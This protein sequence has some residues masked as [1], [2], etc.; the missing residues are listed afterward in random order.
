MS[1][2]VPQYQTR[3]SI[4]GGATPGVR[5]Q[6]PGIC[7]PGCTRLDTHSRPLHCSVE[8]LDLGPTEPWR[9]R[10]SD[11]ALRPAARGHEPFVPGRRYVPPYYRPRRR[12][13]RIASDADPTDIG[14]AFALRPL[15]SIAIKYLVRAGF[16]PGQSAAK[17]LT[18]ALEVIQREIEYLEVGGEERD[19]VS[20][21][22]IE[23]P[24][25]GVMR[26]HPR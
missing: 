25:A 19:D 16:K 13:S 23:Y 20:G 14:E 17:D 1:E 12:N 2:E 18:K 5:V 8:G 26:V 7:R 11:D 9:E 10:A 3:G 22:R 24:E 6:D 4:N 21:H 15:R